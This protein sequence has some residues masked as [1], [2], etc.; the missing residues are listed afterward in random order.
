MTA[1]QV[2]FKYKLAAYSTHKSTCSDP[3]T[4]YLTGWRTQ[5]TPLETITD[6]CS[7]LA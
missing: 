7:Y 1:M 2:N 6:H 4:E 5:Q 3:P